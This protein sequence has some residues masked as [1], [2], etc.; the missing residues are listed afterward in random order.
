MPGSRMNGDLSI[1]F[2]PVARTAD[3][4]ED[5]ESIPSAAPAASRSESSPSSPS[6]VHLEIIFQIGD[7]RRMR[8]WRYPHQAVSAQMLWEDSSLI[9]PCKQTR[10]GAKR[11]AH[12]SA[13]EV[14]HGRLDC[15]AIKRSGLETPDQQPWC[16]PDLQPFPVTDTAG[17]SLVDNCYAA[18][19]AYPSEHCRF[20]VV[21]FRPA[22]KF[23]LVPGETPQSLVA[24]QVRPP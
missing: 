18:V 6:P 13:D 16:P 5:D 3:E 1:A 17:R 20:A 14:V 22:P 12:P 21:S 10:A 23:P 8:R 24:P 7:F 15:G 9:G 2:T 11:Q 19:N 4:P